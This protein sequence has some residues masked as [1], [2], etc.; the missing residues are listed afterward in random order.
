MDKVYEMKCQPGDHPRILVT[1]EF[2]QRNQLSI[3][4]EAAK[5]VLD[6]KSD[7]FGFGIQVA[8]E[9]LPYE[10]VV[11]LFTE[12]YRDKVDKGEAK[13]E[14]ITDIYEATQDFLD[15]MVFAWMKALDERGLSA[16]R[17]V[18][19]LSTWMLIL[20][21]PDVAG[22]LD[23]DSLYE[24]YGRPALCMACRMLGIEFPKELH[25]DGYNE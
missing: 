16:S 20:N 9:F 5:L 1:E 21:R 19:K 8:C 17:S 6:C 12:E 3:N 22:V 4:T 11:H 10:D 25:P 2:V 15:Y 13:H 23:D 24:P 18:I 7:M 14:Q